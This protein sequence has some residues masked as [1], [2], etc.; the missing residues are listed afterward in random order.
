MAQDGTQPHGGESDQRRIAGA[1]DRP[2]LHHE[3]HEE[4]RT[5][6]SKKKR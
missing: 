5:K 2:S 1:V 6:H 4:R 3:G